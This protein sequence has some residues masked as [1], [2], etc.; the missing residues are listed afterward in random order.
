MPHGAG[1]DVSSLLTI[2]VTSSPVPSNPDTSTIRAVFRSFAL[3]PSLV[4]CPKII[5]LDGPQK[6]LPQARIRS[7]GEFARRVRALSRQEALF[8]NT[9]V[10]ASNT[11]LFAAHNLA[12]AISHVNTTFLLSCQHDYQ[13]ARPFDVSGLLKTMVVVPIVRHVLSLIHI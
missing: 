4:S 7:Y 12:A 2:V 5:H 1:T 10:Y 9:R 3:V 8:A 6:S 11:F 13:L